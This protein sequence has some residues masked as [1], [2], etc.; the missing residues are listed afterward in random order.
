M[1]R[2]SRLPDQT[3]TSAS[4]R[5]E[6]WTASSLQVSESNR[7]K[8]TNWS[9]TGKIIAIRAHCLCVWFIGEVLKM[10]E[11]ENVSLRDVEEVAPLDTMQVLHVWLYNSAT[12][13]EIESCVWI[14]WHECVL[15]SVMYV[16]RSCWVTQEVDQ[17]DTFITSTNMPPNSCLDLK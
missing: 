5:P 3:S 11:E 1:I 7:G 17:E 15:G 13:Y 16:G 4:T 10:L 6:R 2:N 14:C 8:I 9:K 12:T